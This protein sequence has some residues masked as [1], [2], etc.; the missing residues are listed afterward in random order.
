MSFLINFEV[1]NNGL[2]IDGDELMMD[3]NFSITVLNFLYF[4]RIIF[5]L[6]GNFANLS[7]KIHGFWNFKIFKVNNLK[8]IF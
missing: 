1:L 3:I 6:I 5:Y 4:L 8:V 2:E 7:L